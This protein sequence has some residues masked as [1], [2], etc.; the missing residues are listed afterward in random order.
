[1][2]KLTFFFICITFFA[3][4]LNNCSDSPN[5]VM[6]DTHQVQTND[7]VKGK[8]V[9]DKP[10]FEY[11]KI[12]G[13][14]LISN[15]AVGADKNCL[16]DFLGNKT[17]T[18]SYKVTSKTSY[19][20]YVHI[21]LD[22]DF[23]LNNEYDGY[24][25]EPNHLVILSDSYSGQNLTTA[26][27]DFIW[28]GKYMAADEFFT[29]ETSMLY[30][31][32]ATYDTTVDPP[33]PYGLPQDHYCIS[34]SA[35]L[36]SSAEWDIAYSYLWILAEDAPLGEFFITEMSIGVENRKPVVTV[37]IDN[38]T[39]P[40][41]GGVA[42]AFVRGRFTGII[43]EMILSEPTNSDGHVSIVGSRLRKNQTGAISFIISRVR[44]ES[45]VYN[46]WNNLVG[47]WPDQ[48]PSVSM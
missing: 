45:A 41:N 25:I 33:I 35:G 21:R 14:V 19:I 44:K 48:L 1:M 37:R 47:D 39:D 16:I 9:K 11:L 6:S 3:F 43:S 28:D 27:R 23:N 24:G 32:L 40:N 18:I 36:E 10:V 26:I 7:L 31:E 30:D 38:D 8:P 29:G 46:P 5:P 12:D 34:I 2:K 15:G 20:T 42:N 22:C 17:H 13:K 4:L